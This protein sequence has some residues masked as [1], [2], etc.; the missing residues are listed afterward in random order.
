MSEDKYGHI[1][2]EIAFKYD[3]HPSLARAIVQQESRWDAL[4]GSNRGAKGLMQLT[5]PTAKML[6]VDDRLDPRQ[7]IEGGIKYFSQL[8]KRYDG[9]KDVALAAY[10]AGP[11]NVARAKARGLAWPKYFKETREY[12]AKINRDY[13]RR[14]VEGRPK[15]EPFMVEVKPTGASAWEMVKAWAGRGK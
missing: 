3:V 6:G 12:V 2:D 1:V 15:V 5:A 8:L 11:T 10:N 9:D 14:L 7:N 4:A 13:E